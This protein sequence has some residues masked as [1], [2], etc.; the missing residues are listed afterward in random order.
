[1]RPDDLLVW[2][3]AIPFQPFRMTL[4]SGRS[5]DIRHPEMLRVG[6]S[7]VNVYSFAGEPTDPYER[8]EM[9]SLLLIERIEPIETAART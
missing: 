7:S 5:Y 8:V 1:M 2:L 4:N 9:V 6:R 3:R